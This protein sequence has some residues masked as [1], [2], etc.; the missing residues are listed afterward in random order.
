MIRYGRVISV[1]VVPSKPIRLKLVMDGMALPSPE[2]RLEDVV[3]EGLE[4][5]YRLNRVMF[6]TT[7]KYQSIQ[8]TPRALV[9]VLSHPPSSNDT[10]LLL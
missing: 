3:I 2:S 10:I 8:V 4:M 1:S 7:S 5:R 9:I 6:N